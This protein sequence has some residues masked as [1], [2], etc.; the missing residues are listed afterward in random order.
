MESTQT[1]GHLRRARIGRLAAT[2]TLTGTLA[3]TGCSSSSSAKPGTS[4]SSS[5]SFTAS[6][7][8]TPATLSPAVSTSASSAVSTASSAPVGSLTGAWKGDYRS[9]AGDDTGTITATFAQVGNTLSGGLTTDSACFMKGSLTGTVSGK[10]VT[11]VAKYGGEKLTFT[12]SMNSP[13]GRNIQGTYEAVTH[14][15]NGSGTFELG[16]TK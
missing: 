4:T 13:N 1:Q 8:S 12:G 7:S 10:T 2:L 5:A 9:T 14:C 11:L 3:I 15:G 6:A 16:H